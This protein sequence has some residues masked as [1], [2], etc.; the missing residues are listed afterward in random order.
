[1]I[2]VYRLVPLAGYQVASAISSCT[3]PRWICCSR[4]CRATDSMSERQATEYVVISRPSRIEPRSIESAYWA[5]G[6][7][8]P[9]TVQLGGS[10]PTTNCHPR[11]DHLHTRP[12][13]HRHTAP[14]YG[15][16]GERILETVASR[17]ES[18]IQPAGW[19]QR[20]CQCERE[21][22]HAARTAD[23]MSISPSQPRLF[24]R[25]RHG[26]GQDS[27]GRIRLEVSLVDTLV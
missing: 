6:R 16:N 24:Q 7:V 22:A 27:A 3:S 10:M 20:I 9:T 17:L 23:S 8:L 4:C 1:M 5:Y 2:A 21:L 15:T 26:V 18:S 25:A 11:R 19:F 12:L 14:L 13:F